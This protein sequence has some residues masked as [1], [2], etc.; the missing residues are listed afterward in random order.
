MAGILYNMMAQNPNIDPVH[1]LEVTIAEFHQRRRHLVECVRFLLEAAE[2]ANSPDSNATYERLSGFVHSEFIS[3]LP[4]Q[5]G[6]TFGLRI[7]KAVESLD[8]DIAKAD[9]ARKN[10]GSNTTAPTGQGMITTTT[11][12]AELICSEPGNLALG[13]DV[14]SS[15]YESLRYE[16]RTLAMALGSISR[17]GHTSPNEVKSMVEWLFLNPNH[18]ITFYMLAALLFSLDPADPRSTPG[19]LRRSLATDNTTMA[20]M[21]QKLAA[22]TEWKEPGLKATILLKWT[23]F[24]TE[25]RHADPSLEHR[26]GFRTDE[27]ETQVWNAVQGDA[28]N[29]LVLAVVQLQR[30][31]GSVPASSFVNS[32]ALTLDQHEHREVPSDDFKHFVLIAFET[33]VRSLITHASSELR[34]IKQRQEDLVH[35]SARTDRARTTSSRFASTIAPESDKSGP[36]PRNDI[37][38][39]FSFIGLLYSA[40]P[41]ERALQFW[42]SGPQGDALHASYLE[43]VENTAGR[44]P[45]FLQWAVWSTSIN[46]ITMSTALYDMLGGLAKGQQC[47]ELA[48]NFMARAGGEVIPG[49]SLPSSSSSGPS[50]SWTVIFGLLDSWASSSMGSR[51]QQPQPQPPLFGLGMSFAGHSTHSAHAPPQHS[52]H[53]LSIGAKEV[54]LAHSFLRLLSSVVTHSVAV[55]VA[56]SGH[57]HFRA[58]P[59]LVSLIPLGVPLELKGAIFDTLAAFCEPGAGIPGVEICKAVW[60]LMERLEVINVRTMP[61]G[62]FAAALPSM[63]GVEAELEEIESVHR[64]YPATI[65]FLKLLSTLIHTPKRVPLKDRVMDTQS[66]STIPET[67]GQP[68]RLPGIGPFTAF[69]VDNVFAKIPNREYSRPSDRWQTN[70]LCLCYI[71]RALASFDLESLVATPQDP[72]LKSESLL[73]LLVHPGYDIMKRLL[74]NS[75]LQAS[76]LSYIVDGV[77]GFEKD[78]ADEE[79]FFRSTIVRVLRVVHRVLEIQDIFLDVLVPLISEFDSVSVVGT[80]HSRSYFTRFEQALSFSPQYIPALA[81][82]IAFPNHSE[83]VLLSIKIITALSL[84]NSSSDLAILI[85]RSNDSE[86]I[87]KGFMH[88]INVESTDDVLHAETLADQTTGAGAPELE[89]GEGSLD[90]AIRLAA[91]DLLIQG[92]N[93]SQRYPNVAHFLLF[94]GTKNE[95][96]VQDPHALG[97]QQT[98]IHVLLD[99]VNMGVP[100]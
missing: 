29:Y 71:E 48:Y 99:L 10:A 3:G 76:V 7:F 66:I 13:Y 92:T 18:A 44:L 11:R 21:T 26:N 12:Y 79:P 85:E 1:C 27:L 23:L 51:H 61:T 53:Q 31:H 40:L 5:G 97:A 32:L 67:L 34:K 62:A 56:I 60:T 94:G 2:A 41:A 98:T 28:F 75:P 74:T 95:Q 19:Q 47:S 37:A 77:E 43:Y 69:V 73:S 52:S 38:M 45:T 70:D 86:R 49:S 55:R 82:Y 24:L 89:E 9:A 88:V 6:E 33:L 39:L 63:K 15:R 96:Q 22:S 64:L 58:I 46:D 30:R 100:V 4:T 8:D 83:L 65:P 54:F 84:S 16:R 90:Q 35:A 20:Y 68:Y 80:V 42:G 59:T 87:L 50:I 72:S 14:L 17:M 57:A 36:P 93:S 78:F 81:A 25:A 91:L